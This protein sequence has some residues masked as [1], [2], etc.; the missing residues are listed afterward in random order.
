MGLNELRHCKTRFPM[1]NLAPNVNKQARLPI[2]NPHTLFLQEI[3][4]W[5]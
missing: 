2:L 5:V 3:E 1:A 4:K